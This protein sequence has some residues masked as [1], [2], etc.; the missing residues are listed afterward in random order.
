M[1]IAFETISLR[2]ICENDTQATQ[3]YGAKIAE[4]LRHRLADLRAST[5]VNDLIA[6]NPRKIDGE[7]VDSMVITLINGHGIVFC[8]N[9]PNNPVADD[10]AIDWARVNRIKIL[11]IGKL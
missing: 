4:V 10:G 5:T 9:H 11:R 6:G 3:D 7:G 2:T 8:A 1:E